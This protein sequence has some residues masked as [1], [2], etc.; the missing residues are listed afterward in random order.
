MTDE[1]A[2]FSMC[3]TVGVGLAVSACARSR[4]LVA[5]H[6]HLN[7]LK[8]NGALYYICVSGR[9]NDI[10]RIKVSSLKMNFL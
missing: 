10:M 3:S 8:L 2:Y 5:Q 7:K 4:V 9:K 1:Q 6:M